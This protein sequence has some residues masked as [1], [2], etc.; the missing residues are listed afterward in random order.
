MH[1]LRKNKLNRQF[2]YYI[3][4][5]LGNT[6]LTSLLYC[7]GLLLF[8]Y[9][10]AYTISFL[11]GVIFSYIMNKNVVFDAPTSSNYFSQYALYYLT[12]YGI[13]LL[14]IH[15]FIQHGIPPLLAPWIVLCVLTPIN[16]YL[17]KGIFRK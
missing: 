15:Q 6:F 10:I 7:L 9:A 5:G 8:P 3:R 17:L 12:Q 16:F 13:G 1:T 2:F 14:L 4:A 11:V